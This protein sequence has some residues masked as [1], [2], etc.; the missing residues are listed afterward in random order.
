MNT[1]TI[2]Q[3]KAYEQKLVRIVRTLPVQRVAEL[4][5]F[6]EF[7]QERA[8]ANEEIL[9]EDARAEDI[10][11][12]EARWDALFASDA[13]QRLLAKLAQEA[14]AEDELGL[15]VEMVFDEDGGLIEPT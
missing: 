7:L 14:L 4:I 8:Q 11:V 5:D 15:T 10:K 6:A 2:K 1:Q 13:S 3:T 9:A 12:S